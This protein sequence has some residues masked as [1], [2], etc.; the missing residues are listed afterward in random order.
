MLRKTFLFGAY[1]KPLERNLHLTLVAEGSAWWRFPAVLCISSWQ[2]LEHRG[3]C[4]SVV[5]PQTPQQRTV[6][7]CHIDGTWWGSCTQR[8]PLPLR[9][10]T[11]WEATATHSSYTATSPWQPAKIRAPSGKTRDFK[12]CCSQELLSVSD[13]SGSTSLFQS[14]SSIKTN[15]NGYF[16]NARVKGLVSLYCW[17]KKNKRD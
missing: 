14:F 3:G 11:K 7:L 4:S 6:A 15:G 1:V 9:T 5:L 2:C 8:A 13:C 10:M 12:F 17:L 16:S